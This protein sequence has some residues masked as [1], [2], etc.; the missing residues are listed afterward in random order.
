MSQCQFTVGQ[1]VTLKAV[2]A[3]DKDRNHFKIGR[4]HHSVKM[5]SMTKKNEDIF[6]CFPEDSNCGYIDSALE[7]FNSEPE[8]PW[9]EHA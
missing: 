1:T 4:I 3:K 8:F 5:L 9:E 2:P 6:S 7:Y